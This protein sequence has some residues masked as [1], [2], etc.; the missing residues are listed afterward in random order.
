MREIEVTV[1]DIGDF[2]N[3]DVIDVLVKPGD[4]VVKEDP[5]VTLET[6]KATLDI[7]SPEAG[8]VVSLALAAGATVSEGDP[9]LV[10]RVSAAEGQSEA[11]H[12]GDKPGNDHADQPDE[13]ETA[14]DPAA[15]G[16]ADP[17][18]ERTQPV[19]TLRAKFGS[20]ILASLPMSM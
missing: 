2:Q 12:G 17:A 10:L 13:P 20:P 18:I 5:L 15:A 4:R 9:I 19:P 3:V 1:P 8:E 7:P 6:D 11:G 14:V 16:G